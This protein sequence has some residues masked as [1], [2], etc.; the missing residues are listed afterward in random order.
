[1]E[2]TPVFP[3]KED[4]LFREKLGMMED[5]G[6]Y[7]IPPMTK[8]KNKDEFEKKADMLCRFEK[9]YYQHFVSQYISKRSPYRS[10]LLYHGLGSG[11]TCSAITIAETFIVNHRIYDEP[12]I[13]VVSK[14]AL[15]E[16][17]SQDIFRMILLTS[18]EFIREQCTSDAYLQMIPDHATLSEEN[19]AKRIKKIINS[20]YK[21]FGYETFANRIKDYIEDGT[22]K[23]RI[24]NKVIIIDEVHNIRSLDSSEKENKKKIIDPILQFIHLSEGNRLI[25]LSATPMFNEAEEILW[26]MSLLMLNDKKSDALQP[27]KLPSFYNA[28]N[29]AIPK[30]FALMKNLSSHYI[31]YIR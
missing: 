31:S 12:M 26:L 2:Y 24:K 28:Q 10:L 7:K 8:I 20:R 27:F 15:K 23:E 18:P 17:F 29:N 16:S 22:I 19:L 13:W 1:M 25:F 11:K 6:I 14:K 5:F 21:F 30:T 3:S 9:T 4:P